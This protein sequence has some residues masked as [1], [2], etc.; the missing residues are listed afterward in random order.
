MK[1]NENIKNE[2]KY[3]YDMDEKCIE[4]YYL[5]NSLP[6]TE[7]FDS[8]CGHEKEVY[9]MFFRCD[10]IGVLSRL[11]R[12]VSRNYSDGNWE[13]VVD[14]TDTL[15]YGCFWLRTKTVLTEDELDA[16]LDN[17]I[18]SIRYWFSD[19]FDEYFKKDEIGITVH[20]ACGRPMN[21]NNKGD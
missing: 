18:Y 7:T 15:P 1:R 12:A 3:P 8:C 13:I 11:G 14:S 16:S 21:V 19:E 4:L 5:L 9:M 6:D 20:D 17:L 2:L 10:N